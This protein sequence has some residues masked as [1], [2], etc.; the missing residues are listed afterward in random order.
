MTRF[1]RE[2][3]SPHLH[4]KNK[5]HRLVGF[6]FYIDKFYFNS[7]VFSASKISKEEPMGDKPH[8]V[9]PGCVG[10][11]V[12]DRAAAAAEMAAKIAKR[13]EIDE[14]VKAWLISAAPG[15]L[16]EWLVDEDVLSIVFTY[17]QFDL[18]FRFD[19]KTVDEARDLVKHLNKAWKNIITVTLRGRSLDEGLDIEFKAVLGTRV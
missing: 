2:F 8:Y 12:T 17:G 3:N 5:T 11:S 19:C 16:Q 13:N 4:I 14:K 1:G 10:A 9:Y 6:V 18:G 15:T 7:I